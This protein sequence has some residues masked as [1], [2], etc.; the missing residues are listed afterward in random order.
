MYSSTQATH[1]FICEHHRNVAQSIRLKR[2]RKD[3]ED[4]YESGFSEVRGGNQPTDINLCINTLVL[5]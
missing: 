2:R 4:E 3:S 1:K 5:P